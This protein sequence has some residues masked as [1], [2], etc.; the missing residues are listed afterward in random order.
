[1]RTRTFYTSIAV[2][3]ALC[4]MGCTE[5][6]DMS[7]RYVFKYDCA[8]QYLEKHPD[9]YSSYI[10]LLRIIKPSE[11]TETTFAQLLS[12]RGH[13]TVFAPTNKAMQAF[14][15]ELAA[16]EDF[17]TAP[18]FDAFTDSTKLDSIRSLIVKNSIIDCGD[19]SE[20]YLTYDFP[21]VE[22]G[23]FGY[24]NMD[25][26]RM[27]INFGKDPDSLYINR[28]CPVSQRNCDIQV[29]NG[30]IHQMEKVITPNVMT[31]NEILNMI[32]EKEEK[33]FLVMARTIQ[34]CGLMDTLDAERDEKY[35][36]MYQKRELDEFISMQGCGFTQSN[37]Y[38]PQHRKYGFTI[39]SET[40][41]FWEEQIGKDATE[42]TPEDV[43]AWV[44]AQ[45]YYPE[46]T[47]DDNYTDEDNMLYQWV[48]YHMLPQK[49]SAG[50]LVFHTN[51]YGYAV[52][53]APY[54][55]GI[56]VY[57][58]YTTMGPRRLLKFFESKESQ[59]VFLNR[60]PVLDDKRKGGTYHETYCSPE[61]T[62]CRIYKEDPELMDRTGTNGYIYAIDKPLAYSDE[63]R[64]D[65]GKERLRIDASTMLPELMNNDI[66]DE[67][68]NTP[69]AAFVHLPNDGVYKYCEN[70]SVNEG[71]RLCYINGYTNN[72][73][74]HY[75]GDVLTAVGFYDV[76]LKLPPVPVTDVYEIRYR[77]L[78]G[79]KLAI[80]QCFVGEDPEH[81]HAAGI[82]VDLTLD[83]QNDK[84]YASKLK[85]N[86]SWVSDTDDEDA[87]TEL[88]KN[89]HNHGWM[90]A[91]GSTVDNGAGN[92]TD[93]KMRVQS[94]VQRFIAA[95]ERLEAGKTYYFQIRS[96]QDK[97]LSLYLDYLELC[98]KSVYDNP[99]KSEDTW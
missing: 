46:A 60:F 30:V 96:V 28:T 93:V 78:M 59:G 70:M 79:Y 18:S 26:R 64:E 66:R 69:D 42:I 5:N 92:G 82:P 6:I 1:M 27:T 68:R 4:L 75:Q 17:L 10:E 45:N 32:L 71:T 90:K 65:L 83:W 97:M 47:Q 8:M 21:L 62:G 73:W 94:N 88:D 43:Q 54:D 14:L 38:T 95:R 80:S 49:M 41:E 35:E 50:K 34:A 99:N 77:T 3:L 55:Y 87:N 15:E 23:E 84:N 61:K 53:V 44:A 37:A 9:D 31:L 33:G 7:A 11:K 20:A 63:V 16:N 13:Y 29:T 22:N 12:A 48:T 81:M 74:V 39:F 24:P 89:M 36:T 76:T 58:Y 2:L 57:D 91:E 56:P 25:E 19:E 40:D 98:P 51:E 72:Y 86:T 85:L 52:K 67:H